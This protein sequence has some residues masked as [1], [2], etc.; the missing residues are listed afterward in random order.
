M[1]TTTGLLLVALGS[2]GCSGRYEV[3]ATDGAGGRKGNAGSESTK[4]SGGS[5]SRLASGGSTSAGAAMPAG[6]SVRAPGEP[7][8]QLVDLRR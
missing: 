2:W 8:D 4:A 5:D 1:R 7:V 3:G 6:G